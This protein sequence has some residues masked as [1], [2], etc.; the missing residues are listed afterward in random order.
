[1]ILNENYGNLNVLDKS[2]LHYITYDTNRYGDNVKKIYK[3][4][5]LKNSMVSPQSKVEIDPVKPHSLKHLV[6]ILD[7]P[8][9]AFVVFRI[10]KKQICL[11]TTNKTMYDSAYIDSNTTIIVKPSILFKNLGTSDGIPKYFNK[12]SELKHYLKWIISRYEDSYELSKKLVWDLLVVYKDMNVSNLW[13]SRD[14]MKQ[15][16]IPTPKEKKAYQKFILD[17]KYAWEEKC[18]KFIE[19][20]RPDNQNSKDIIKELFARSSIKKFKFKGDIYTLDNVPLVWM[21]DNDRVNYLKYVSTNKSNPIRAIAIEFKMKGMI[22]N[23]ISVK[24]CDYDSDNFS[25][26]QPLL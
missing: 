6:E 12:D 4:M 11:I 16:Y 15:G 2:F 1:M 9:V 22:P 17:Y 7:N 23:V 10:N 14:E 20:N 13:V 5:N 19:D 3:N 24:Y 8:E 18:K 21:H 26:Y 25:N